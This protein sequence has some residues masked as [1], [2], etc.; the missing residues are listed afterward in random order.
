MIRYVPDQIMKACWLC[1]DRTVLRPQ[2]IILKNLIKNCVFSNISES[3]NRP[4][5]TA[6]RPTGPRLVTFLC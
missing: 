1:E 5:A 4:V 6:S 3:I 2:G